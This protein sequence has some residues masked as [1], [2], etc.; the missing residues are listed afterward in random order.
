[1]SQNGQGETKQ[2]LATVFI[3][4]FADLD[5]TTDA[6]VP[7]IDVALDMLARATRHLEDKRRLQVLQQHQLQQQRAAEDEAV[8]RSLRI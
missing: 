6:S 7:S 2:P 1:M 4:L 5:V 3:R 8:R